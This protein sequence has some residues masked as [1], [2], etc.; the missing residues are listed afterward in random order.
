L[1][2]VHE[3]QDADGV[4]GDVVVDRVDEFHVS[5]KEM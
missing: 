1:F 4:L 2:V 5:L 3:P